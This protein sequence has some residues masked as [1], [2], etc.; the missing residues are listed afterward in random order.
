MKKSSLLKL[1]VIVIAC[2]PLIYLAIVWN[3]IPEI[4]ALHYNE[5]LQADRMG[6]KSELWIVV[7]I[8]AAV[9]IGVF[10]LLQNLHIFDPKRKNALLSATFSKLAAGIVV[11][12]SALNFI[13][14]LSA[15]NGSFLLEK[16]LF[17]LLGLLFAFMGNNF[18]N[19]KPNYFAGFRLP[20]TLSDDNNWRLTHHLAS[21]IWF[22]GG[23]ILAILGLL[24]P[25]KFMIPV[26]IGLMIIMII[27]PVVYSYRLFKTKSQQ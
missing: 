5:K 13:I 6:S 21:K 25:L 19:I 3:S 24:L 16:S 14:I 10:F 12:M 22:T 9:S 15:S 26:F 1:F 11:F 7:G 18:Y 8:V 27:I 17:P 23:I 20:W 4:I 2:L